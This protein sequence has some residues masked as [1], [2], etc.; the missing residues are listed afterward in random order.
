MGDKSV[1]TKKGDYNVDTP[2]S[3]T[4][5]DSARRAAKNGGKSFFIV[6]LAVFSLSF[7]FLSFTFIILDSNNIIPASLFTKILLAAWA[8][9]LLDASLV[10]LSRR[11][12][13]AAVISIVICVIMI[14]V[15]AFGTYL[16]HKYNESI[17]EVEK[18]RTVYA[19][20]GV[21]VKKDSCY[22]PVTI[23]PKNKKKKSYVIPGDSLDGCRVG[24]ML[25][26]VDKGYNSQAV[27]LYRKKHDIEVIAYDDFGSMID[28]LR[29]DVVDAIIFNE[30]YMGI[31]FDEDTDFYE[32]AVETDRIAIETEH[33][34]EVMKADVVSESFIVYISG[35]DTTNSSGI[36]TD[37]FPEN[38]RSDVNIVAAVD[39]VK[40][41][42]LLIN[43]PRDYYVP[44]WGRSYAMDKL[45]HAGVYGVGASI[46]TIEQLYG[47]EINYYVRTNI[48]SLVKVVD[49]LGGITVHSDF[50]FF[51]P[52]G[53]WEYRQFYVGDNE[54]DGMGALCF[55]RERHSF[56][57]GD[58]QRGIHQQEV[59]RAIIDKACSPAII[60]HFSDVLDVATK[61]VQT[62]LGGEE[63][64]ALIKMQLS[65]MASWTVETISVD[66]YGAYMPS[67]AIGSD[68]DPVWVMM[69]YYDSVMEAQNAL[70]QFLTAE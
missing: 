66:G 40:K 51:A 61:S 12:K 4:E 10:F 43:T 41:R 58:R 68:T 45:T 24:T 42:V 30:A 17:H 26:N 34:A 18:D 21:Y 13:I 37:E 52:S 3:I 56:E 14:V 39:P 11:S 23:E 1:Y 46:D 22:A 69:P 25:L 19:Y 20:I 38:A 54:I 28:A 35:I 57:N 36:D 67:Y 44:L 48:F 60:A 29:N 16:L 70:Y 6:A 50:E 31:F 9:V 64:N 62:N 33:T 55:I 5:S 2:I 47:I 15:S 7:A 8:F 49:A 53:T 32:W 63:I 59:I 65:D 27:R